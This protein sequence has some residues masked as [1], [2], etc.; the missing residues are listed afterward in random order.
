MEIAPDVV[1][2]PIEVSFVYHS[3]PSGPA[4]IRHGPL[5]VLDRENLLVLSGTGDVVQP[6][7]GVIAIGSGGPYAQAAAKALTQHST[8]DAPAIVRTSLEIAAD[9]CI[10]TN[11][12]IEVVEV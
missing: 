9:L 5:I 4:A 12:N 1:I 2:R 10:Y 3:A 6:T 7:D 8:L 11:R